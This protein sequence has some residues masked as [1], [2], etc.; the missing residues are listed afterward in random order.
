MVLQLAD[1]VARSRGK[2]FLGRACV[3]CS[4]FRFGRRD[5]RKP[6]RPLGLR[7]VCLIHHPRGQYTPRYGLF[8]ARLKPSKEV[9]GSFRGSFSSTEASFQ[10]AFEL[11]SYMSTIVWSRPNQFRSPVLLSAVA[12]YMSAFLF[13]KVL[14]RRRGH[15]VHMPT[16]IKRMCSN[17]ICDDV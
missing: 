14:R 4:G 11:L 17:R 7:L 15:L 1:D 2:L 6:H 16:C 5:Y 8:G 12:V 9:Q 3:D 10:N 13:G